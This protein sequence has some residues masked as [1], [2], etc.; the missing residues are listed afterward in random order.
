MMITIKIRPELRFCFL[1]VS[2]LVHMS[3]SF[4]PFLPFVK[5]VSVQPGLALL[6]SEKTLQGTSH[7]QGLRLS[8]A[9]LLTP[10]VFPRLLCLIP[11]FLL[12]GCI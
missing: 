5:I 2:C 3:Y 11:S 9:E 8:S 10:N 7:I 12:P 4:I 1:I 6:R